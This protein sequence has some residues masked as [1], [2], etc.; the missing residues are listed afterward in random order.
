MHADEERTTGGPEAPAVDEPILFS[1]M[2]VLDYVGQESLTA[3]GGARAGSKWER[4]QAAY[5]ATYSGVEKT[6]AQPPDVVPVPA[7]KGSGPQPNP[8]PAPPPDWRAHVIRR[9]AVRLALE[10]A[11]SN[12]SLAELEALDPDD[13]A[14]RVRTVFQIVRDQTT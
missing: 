9:Q 3:P 5:R 14:D 7:K 10:Y 2:E 6:R 4:F 1:T 8:T 13:M 11:R 12:L